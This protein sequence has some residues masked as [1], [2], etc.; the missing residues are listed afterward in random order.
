MRQILATVLL[1]TKL[2][3]DGDTEYIVDQF[4]LVD[5]EGNV[6]CVLREESDHSLLFGRLRSVPESLGFAHIQVTE[7]VQ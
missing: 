2:L 5:D 1:E 6:S 7:S 3:H 4:I